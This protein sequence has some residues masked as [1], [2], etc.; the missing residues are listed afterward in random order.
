M[1]SDLQASAPIP[2]I[3]P[4]TPKADVVT[5]GSVAASAQSP[6]FKR[7][8]DARTSDLLRKL[9]KA[10]TRREGRSIEQRL[11]SYWRTPPNPDAARLYR[12]ANRIGKM[13]DSALAITMFDLLE[14][15]APRWPEVYAQRAYFKYRMGRYQEALD[16]ISIALQLQPSHFVAMSGK[17][18]TLVAMKRADEARNAL[19]VAVAIHPWM[20]ER[21]LLNKG[22]IQSL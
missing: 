12:A 16:D 4:Y 1:A 10:K 5:T 7:I 3:A 21:K 17:F 2:G 8:S 14:D 19:E 6:V 15:K 13:G 20:R 18:W 11:M 9:I 22:E